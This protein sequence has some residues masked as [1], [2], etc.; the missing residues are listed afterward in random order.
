MYVLIRRQCLLPAG[1]AGPRRAIGSLRVSQARAPTASS[2]RRVTAHCT[3]VV[4]QQRYNSMRPASYYPGDWIDS[5]SNSTTGQQTLRSASTG[6][7]A[8]GS[9][10]R[11]HFTIARADRRGRAMPADADCLRRARR[12]AAGRC[13]TLNG[14]VGRVSGSGSQAVDAAGA[15]GYRRGHRTRKKGVGLVGCEPATSE[16]WVRSGGVDHG[17]IFPSSGDLARWLGHPARPFRPHWLHEWRW[18]GRWSVVG[19]SPRPA[20]RPSLVERLARD[21]RLRLAT[22]GN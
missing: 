8:G 11:L 3:R 18:S 10:W 4:L 5:S 22:S 12:S 19:R 21:Q 20:S 16:L 7:T 9:G 17:R 13:V 1:D 2:P 14:T 6:D 15:N